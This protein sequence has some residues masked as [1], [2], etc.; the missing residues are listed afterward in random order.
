MENFTTLLEVFDVFKFQGWS[1]FLRIS[2]DIFRGLIFA[3]NST[4]VPSDEDNISLRSIVRS[5]ELQVLPSNIAEITNTP[6]DVILCHVGKRWWEELSA[7]EEEVVEILT[8]K[9]V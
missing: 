4:L 6:N 2:K 8:G 7:I 3:F 1:D 9:E 5:F